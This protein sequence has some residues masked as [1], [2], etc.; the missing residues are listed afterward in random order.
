MV[1]TGSTRGHL[2]WVVRQL[3]I[4]T[5]VGMYVVDAVSHYQ[6]SYVLRMYILAFTTTY[7]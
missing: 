3:K 2:G 7:Y 1:L 5:Y 6:C 4:T